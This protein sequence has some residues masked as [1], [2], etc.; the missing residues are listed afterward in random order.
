MP[1]KLN[2]KYAF[3]LEDLDTRRWHDSLAQNSLSTAACYLFRFGFLLERTGHT[4][5]SF[6]ALP[7]KARDDLMSD[8]I[9]ALHRAGRSTTA[10]RLALASTKSWLEWRGLKFTRRFKLPRALATHTGGYRIPDQATVGRI[11]DAG[12]PR[13]R[14]GGSLMGLAGLRPAILG[15]RDGSV[16]LQFKHLPEAHLTP[17]GIVFDHIPTMIEVPPHLSKT[18]NGFFTF[19]GSEGCAYLAA[20]VQKRI[21]AGEKLTLESAVVPPTKGERPF[22]A[23]WSVS[24]LVR[25]PMRRAGVKEPPYILR[26]YFANRCSQTNPQE[27]HPEWREFFM[28]HNNSISFTYA[29]NKRHLPPDFLEALRKGYEAAL[30]H[31]ET[32]N[33]CP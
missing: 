28:G 32:R 31:L 9:T 7:K 23:T 22:M 33:G 24:E 11:F 4:Q 1:K 29:F 18:R 12:N 2:P 27:L 19:F 5:G 30:E 10:M 3:L 16:G 21:Q 15:N 17:E 8:Y 13:E 14:L 20:D 6:L 25:Q 26:S